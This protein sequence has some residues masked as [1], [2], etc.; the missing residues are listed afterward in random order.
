MYL[1]GDLPISW[2]CLNLYA[3]QIAHKGQL[4]PAQHPALIDAESWASVS[5]LARE[6]AEAEPALA[7]IP[8]AADSPL[9]GS[10]FELSV[11]PFPEWLLAI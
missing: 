9:E 6:A 11:P 1:V 4:Y 7:G 8:V 10:G 3:G 2:F 5:E